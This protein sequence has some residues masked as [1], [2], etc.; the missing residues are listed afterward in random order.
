M[1]VLVKV[2]NAGKRLDQSKSSVTV[3]VL[4]HIHDLVGGDSDCDS[5]DFGGSHIARDQ[6]CPGSDGGV[7]IHPNLGD[8]ECARP[9][10]ASATANSAADASAAIAELCP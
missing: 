6:L 1:L 7:R 3:T 2:L 4:V 9:S 8:A 5:T 10:K